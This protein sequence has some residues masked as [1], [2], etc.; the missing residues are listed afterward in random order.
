MQLRPHLELAGSREYVQAQLPHL[1][2]IT[3]QADWATGIAF[4]AGRQFRSMFNKY[5]DQHRT[6]FGHYLPFVT[7]GLRVKCCYRWQAIV[8]PTMQEAGC[9]T[10]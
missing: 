10:T 2:L 5:A 3:T 6:A 7:L 8:N 1:V 4:R 9:K